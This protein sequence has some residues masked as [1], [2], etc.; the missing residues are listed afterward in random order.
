MNPTKIE[1]VKNPDGSQGFSANP[2]KG[3]CPVG[4]PYCYAHSFY[5][6][7]KLDPTLRFDPK[8][9]ESIERRK[10]PAGIF[11]CSTMELFHPQIKKEWGERI[12]ETIKKCPQHRFYILTK[13]PEHPSI[14]F[15]QNVWVGVSVTTLIDLFRIDWFQR[16][17][18]NI[19]FISFEPLLEKIDCALQGGVHWIIIGCQT[20]KNPVIPQKEWIEILIEQADKYK[21]PVFIKNN[22][23][24]YLKQWGIET[25]KELPGDSR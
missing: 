1:W 20:G 21:I 23:D 7:F 6:R 16:R 14:Y 15:P 2:I 22:L 24:P 13:L 18:D 3:L 9:L 19:S 25:R 4:C 11:M 17:C 5:K 12:F 10:K 8:V